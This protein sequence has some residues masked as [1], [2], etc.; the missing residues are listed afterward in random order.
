MAAETEFSKAAAATGAILRPVKFRL[1]QAGQR[2][3]YVDQSRTDQ[4]EPLLQALPPETLDILA[5]KA[6]VRRL[7]HGELWVSRTERAS[8]IAIIVEGGL[9]STTFTADGK[10]FVFSIN[11]RRRP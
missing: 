10:E 9:R 1:L 11:H 7:A 2:D 3:H 8:G 6:I 4:F 5:A